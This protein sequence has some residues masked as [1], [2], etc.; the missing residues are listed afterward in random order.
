MTS[1]SKEYFQRDTSKYCNPS[2]KRRIPL[3]WLAE[4]SNTSPASSR[5]QNR[6][7]NQEVLLPSFVD[8]RRKSLQALYRT[9]DGSII[10][11][12]KSP[13]GSVD[14]PIQPL[15]DLI[16]KS[17]SY[18]TLSSCSG[19]LSL[20]DPNG[21]HEGMQGSSPDAED[22]ETNTGSGKGRGGWL[23]I[24]HDPIPPSELVDCF[25]NDGNADGG[26]IVSGGS[27]TSDV[28]IPW[29]FKLEPMLLHI[30]ARS[31]QKGKQLLQIALELGFR[32]SGLVISDSRVT[33]AIRG[34]SLALCVPLAPKGPLRPSSAYLE[35][36]VR[37]ANDRLQLNWHQLDRLYDR[38]EATIFRIGV[39]PK[40]K[41]TRIPSL[42]L[43]SAA[44][45][46][47]SMPDSS[48]SNESDGNDY[49]PV[50]QAIYAFG[51]YGT[52]PESNRHSAQRS[53]GIYALQCQSHNDWGSDDWLTVKIQNPTDGGTMLG[54]LEVSWVPKL[55]DCQGMGAIKLAKR[56]NL[57]L[58]WG[59]RMGPKKPVS[60]IHLFNPSG[61]SLSIPLDV[62]GTPP[63]PRWGHSMVALND[64]SILVSGGCN[65]EEGAMD[66]VYILHFCETYLFWERRSETLPIPL[67]HHMSIVDSD[68]A[69]VF[70]GLQ[71]TSNLLEPFQKRRGTAKRDELVWA[72]R[73]KSTK[74]DSITGKVSSSVQVIQNTYLA[75]TNIIVSSERNCVNGLQRFGAASSLSSS[76]MLVSGGLAS[77]SDVD[78]AAPLESYFLA[79][80]RDRV[81]ITRVPL[82][83]SDDEVLDFGSLVHHASVTIGT[84]EF[85]L[86]GGGATSFAFGH[87][88]ASSYHIRLELP[89]TNPQPALSKKTESKP[90]A[91]N[92][93]IDKKSSLT[94]VVSVAPKDAKAVKTKLRSLGWLDK[95]YRMTKNSAQTIAVPIESSGMDSI[96]QILENPSEPW[97]SLLL[98]LGEEDMPFSTSQFAAKGKH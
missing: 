92:G 31:L 69:C 88:F 58:L 18:C 10:G 61:G 23:L 24:S 81:S 90:V 89:S 20:F 55:P 56:S 64:Q 27:G 5:K 54:Q 2:N 59:G 7:G 76:L 70:G 53:P 44:T 87:S 19:R 48:E 3:H 86:I 46:A 13:K 97:H 39:T 34:H 80:D 65:L 71:S 33:V 22:H 29:V 49:G 85:L 12:D 1:E 78:D 66:D 11:T 62:R 35:A 51:G 73:I 84:N 98:G 79:G 41:A 96:P 47:I 67:F 93:D 45:V 68:T 14:A 40:I 72:I 17:S 28:M 94:Y 75:A 6:D 15:V 26:S 30:A 4:N 38:V 43:W 52:G 37:Q 63:T 8:L 9:T 57:I 91:I 16:N 25:P 21:R 50:T 77:S 32:E 74:I 95:R 42:N 83:Y 36:L 60:D 82:E